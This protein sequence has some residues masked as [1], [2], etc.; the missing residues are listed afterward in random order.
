MT[1]DALLWL[2]GLA[3]FAVGVAFVEDRDDETK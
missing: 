3:V 1:P 2:F